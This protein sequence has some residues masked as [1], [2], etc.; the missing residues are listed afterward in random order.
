MVQREFDPSRAY[1]II[2]SPDIY[3][4]VRSNTLSFKGEISSQPDGFQVSVISNSE[5]TNI[6]TIDRI[7]LFILGSKNGLSSK[8]T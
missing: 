3:L 7:G 2:Y 4:R 5:Q 8:L 1:H 6:M